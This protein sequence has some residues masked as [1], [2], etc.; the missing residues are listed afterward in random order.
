MGLATDHVLQGPWLLIIA[1]G[2]LLTLLLTRFAA[3]AQPKRRL[4]GPKGLPII[5]SAHILPKEREWLVYQEW[6]SQYGGYFSLPHTPA[7]LR[8]TNSII[9]VVTSAHFSR[10]IS[11]LISIFA[12]VQ[13]PT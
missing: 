13:V 1:L 3:W 5:G 11:S 7:H 6:A 9:A 12:C 4:P 8:A 10:P 2:L